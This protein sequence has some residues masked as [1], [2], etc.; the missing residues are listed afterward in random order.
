MSRFPQLSDGRGSLKDIQ[1]LV[2]GK[3]HQSLFTQ[4]I[5]DELNI[6]STEIDW[7][8]PIKDDDYA[9]Y[10]DSSFLERIPGYR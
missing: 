5:K 7:V 9:E 8:S 3:K 10:R 2:N 1:V 6:N 4:S